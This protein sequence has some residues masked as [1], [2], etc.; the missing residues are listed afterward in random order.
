MITVFKIVVPQVVLLEALAPRPQQ[1]ELG[2]CESLALAFEGIILSK[3]F[4]LE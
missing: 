2:K 1:E 4:G 3:E